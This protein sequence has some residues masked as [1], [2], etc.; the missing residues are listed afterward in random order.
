MIFRDD[1][2]GRPNLSI[3]LF[4]EVDA[5]FIKYQVIHHVAIITEHM[6]RMQEWLLYIEANP[7]IQPQLHC[8]S[9][10]KALTELSDSELYA[11]LYTAIGQFKYYFQTKPTILYPPWNRTNELVRQTAFKL[12]LDVSHEKV[13]LSQY[14][15]CE[16]DVKE[17]VINFHFWDEGDRSLIEDALKVWVSKR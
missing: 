2:I 15:R 14:I 13:S 7:H 12:G 11:Q 9:H 3:D 8:L 17:G 16:G 4:K 6:D 10:D 5:L 1:D